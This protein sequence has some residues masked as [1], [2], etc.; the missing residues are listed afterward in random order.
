LTPVK[1][2]GCVTV[3]MALNVQGT[4][5]LLVMPLSN[6]TVTAGWIVNVVVGP[7]VTPLTQ[8]SYGLFAKVQ[9]VVPIA[10][11]TGVALAAAWVGM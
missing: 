9:V 4:L 8:T 3:P 1:V 11:Q 2:I 7:I 6:S 10:P 5:S